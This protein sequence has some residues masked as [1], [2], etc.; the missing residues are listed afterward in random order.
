MWNKQSRVTVGLL[1]VIGLWMSGCAGDGTAP[2]GSQSSGATFTPKSSAA[3]Q[4]DSLQ[5]CLARIPSSASAGV[6]QIVEEGCRR[7]EAIRQGIVGSATAKSGDRVAAGTYGDS[8]Q[9][10]LARI[11]KDASAGQKMLAEASCQRDEASR[12]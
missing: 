8:L 12:R 4:S 9:T 7:D 3:V 2:S 5:S 10:C 1:T 11:P 6:R